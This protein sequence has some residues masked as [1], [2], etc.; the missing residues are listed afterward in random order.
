MAPSPF[1]RDSHSKTANEMRRKRA[2]VLIRI[3]DRMRRIE[4]RAKAQREEAVRREKTAANL[5]NLNR[6]RIINHAQSGASENL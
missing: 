5:G 3:E 1:R 6:E 2:N 4:A